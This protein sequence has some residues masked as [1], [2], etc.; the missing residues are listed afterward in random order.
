MVDW[1][2]LFKW[3][4]GYQDGTKQS[5]FKPMS[6]EDRKWLEEAMKQFT[7]NDTDRLKEIVAE[8]KDHMTLDKEKLLGLLDELLEIIEL[9][10]RNSLNMCYSGSMQTLMDIIFNNPD[11]RV[12]QEACS[13]FSFSNQNNVD[14]QKVTFKLG[15]LNLMHQYVKETNVKNKEAVISALSAFLRG[16]NT[17]GKRAFLKEYNGLSFIK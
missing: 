7:F 16:I 13:I 3:S 17:D 10:V 5:D 9:H 14:V 11:E 1:N 6:A 2:G 8:I 15:A 4:T 12:R